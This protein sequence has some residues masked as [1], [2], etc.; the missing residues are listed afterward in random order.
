MG[1]DE[2]FA[3]A[4]IRDG[5]RSAGASHEGASQVDQVGLC[6]RTATGDAEIAVATHTA[7]ADADSVFQ[8]LVVVSRLQVCRGA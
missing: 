7:A 2:G 4:L 8:E 6:L 3:E 5:H 1:A